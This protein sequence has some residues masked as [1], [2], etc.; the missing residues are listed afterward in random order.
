MTHDF[1]KYMKIPDHFKVMYPNG[2]IHLQFAALPLN[3]TGGDPHSTANYLM[4]GYWLDLAAGEA[5]KYHKPVNV[6][7]R[8]QLKDGMSSW[9]AS[10][11]MTKAMQDS[12]MDV[13]SWE[14]D[15]NGKYFHFCNN[16]TMFGY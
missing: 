13:D 7:N 12:Q 8:A 14:I 16:E 2:G 5:A 1:K 3:L 10:L 9:P 6:V 15:P 4:N 11:H